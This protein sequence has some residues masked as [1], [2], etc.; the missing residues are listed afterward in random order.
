[1]INLVINMYLYLVQRTSVWKA[2]NPI[3]MFIQNEKKNPFH[4]HCK[5]VHVKRDKYSINVN[6]Y[7]CVA[8][9]SGRIVVL[10]VFVKAIFERKMSLS[11]SV[12]W[13]TKWMLFSFEFVFPMRIILQS[14]NWLIIL[15]QTFFLNTF[16][17][18]I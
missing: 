3:N 10:Y 12:Q 2:G 15:K 14:L 7:R 5:R 16:F 11:I 1:M 9:D 13:L 6:K 8:V 18:C 4:E 17:C